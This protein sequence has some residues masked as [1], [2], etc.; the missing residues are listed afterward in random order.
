MMDKPITHWLAMVGVGLWVMGRDA[1]T[2]GLSRRIVKT[3]A[4]GFL[5]AGLS[6]DFSSYFG[7]SESIAAVIIMAFGLML[8][9]LITAIIADR[10][11]IKEMISKRF[12][13]R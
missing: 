11:F 12:G 8:L 5:A 13:G 10:T 3:A 2:E 7:F 4:S 6:S 1:E 9:D